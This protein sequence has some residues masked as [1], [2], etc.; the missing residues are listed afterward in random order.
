MKAFLRF[1]FIFV[2]SAVFLGAFAVTETNAQQ[3][4]EILKRMEIHRQNITS[5][6]SNV[7]MVKYDPVLKVSDT[8]E[9][10]SMY[11]PL[12]G[13][14]ALVRIDWT[15]PAQETL[16]VVKDQYVIYR[17]RLNQYITGS[18]KD[19]KGSGK[20]N[21]ALSFMNMSKAELKANYTI[22]YLGEENVSDGTRTAHLQLTPKTAQSY[23]SAELWVDKD[24]MPIQ[25][26]IIEKSNDT[27]TI[28]LSNI[29][30]NENINA[31]AFDV[32]LPKDAKQIKG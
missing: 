29:K 24:G 15:K 10:T 22:V 31:N 16:S 2:L 25:A 21:N 27:T 4:N 13:R 8:T 17:P 18:T 12:K 26:K 14:N 28:L 20:A 5:I 9:G 1:S 6:R 19:A 11:V 30:K 7:T 3:I 23:K 32:K